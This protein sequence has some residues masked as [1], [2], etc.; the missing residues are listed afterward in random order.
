[1]QQAAILAEVRVVGRHNDGDEDYTATR[2]GQDV[3]STL[4]QVF[5]EAIVNARA[6]AWVRKSTTTVTAARKRYRM[7]HRACAMKLAQL[8]DLARIPYKI[9]GDV[10]EF[11]S[12]PTVGEDVEFTYYLR[13]SLLCAEQT[14]GLITAVDTSARTVSFATLPVNRV[15]SASLASGNLI[16]IVHPNGWHEL[17][18]V[19]AVG[20]LTGA[21]PYVFTFPAGTDL[22]DVEVGD[23]VRAA[24]QTDW[25]C[26]P[27]EFHS[28]LCVY[29]A[30]RIHRSKGNEGKAKALEKQ[31]GEDLAR[32]ATL[33]EPRMQAEP[34]VCVPD[35]G[36]IRG[37][38][39][40]AQWGVGGA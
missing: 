5:G 30:A 34:E 27:D 35:H 1:V 7:P 9:F 37:R 24:E 29:T 18:L 31:A 2:I 16:D 20:T 36:P 3:T 25:P 19:G 33:I 15:T 23:Y 17:S 8:S 22:T 13:P 21:G 10:I 32:F 4:Q 6:G 39:S 26:L 14:A 28:A 38:R 12:Q 40:W 11:S